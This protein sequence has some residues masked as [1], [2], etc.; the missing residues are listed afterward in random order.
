MNNRDDS[1]RTAT[2][3]RAK[4]P[5]RTPELKVYGKVS[6]LTQSASGCAQSDNATCLGSPVGNMG[7]LPHLRR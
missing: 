6:T 5:Y 3:C 1:A 7:P 4:R 2:D